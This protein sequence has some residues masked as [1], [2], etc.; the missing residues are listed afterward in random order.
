MKLHTSLTTAEVDAALGRAKR[1]G[2]ITWDVD[3]AV[4]TPGRS[5]THAHGYEVQLGTWDQD[6]LP[7]G[8]TDQY[9]KRLRVRRARNS[10][11]GENRWA[12]TWHEWGWFM[13]ELFAADPNARWGANP[14]RCARPEYAWGYASEADFHRKTENAFRPADWTPPAYTA[15]SSANQSSR[16]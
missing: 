12:A 6:S 15:G 13:A 3:F 16:R 7:G 4:F 2:L 14:A 10:D 11:H 1:K 5:L 8:Y 9:G